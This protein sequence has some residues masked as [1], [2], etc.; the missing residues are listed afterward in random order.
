MCG[1]SSRCC[2]AVKDSA[3]LNVQRIQKSEDIPYE[4]HFLEK[5]PP[6]IQTPEVVLPGLCLSVGVPSV[7]SLS[8]RPTAQGLTTVPGDIIPLSDIQ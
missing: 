1:T 2:A 6:K 4:T 3:G 7:L 8:P 5:K